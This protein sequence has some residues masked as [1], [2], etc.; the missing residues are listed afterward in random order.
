MTGEENSRGFGFTASV[1][2]CRTVEFGPQ[3]WF[4]PAA[5]FDPPA[6]ILPPL[7][8]PLSSGTRIPLWLYLWDESPS[9]LVILLG[10]SYWFK[11]HRPTQCTHDQGWWVGANKRPSRE[12][13]SDLFSPRLC[14]GRITADHLA[15]WAWSHHS[16]QHRGECSRKADRDTFLDVAS[17]KPLGLFIV[18]VE[19]LV[20][21]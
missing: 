17:P 10:W 6:L 9:L 11:S 20:G 3:A 21:I 5:A 15:W 18:E 12:A 7:P 8:Q 14:R 16:T 1:N 4:S 19:C 2:L 13:F